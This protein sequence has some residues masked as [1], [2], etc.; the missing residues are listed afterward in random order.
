ME[1]LKEKILIYLEKKK[2]KIKITKLVKLFSTNE[3]EKN[4][5]LNLIRE[6][7]IEGK[8]YINNSDECCK[9]PSNDNL[10][11][12]KLR[13]DSKGNYFVCS[14]TRVITINEKLLNNALLNDIVVV[15]TD[16]LN[17]LKNCGKVKK[18]IKRHNSLLVVDYNIVDNKPCFK[19]VNNFLDC[20][21]NL[22]DKYCK[23][24]VPGDRLVLKV[25]DHKNNNKLDFEFVESLGHKD[26]PNLE[27][28]TLLVSKDI[29]IDFNEKVIKELDDIP[30]CVNEDEIK[31]RLDLR[32]KNIF[33]IDG[34]STKD[35]DDAVSIEK[36]ENGNYILG[37]HIADVAHYVK[38]NTAIFNEALNRGT[39]IYITN[40]VIPMLPRKLSNGICSLNPN[41]DR[42]TMSCIMEVDP[43]GNVVNHKIIDSV[44][45]S[46]MR[47]TYEDVNKVLKEKQDLEEYKPFKQDLLLMNE[48]SNILRE[49]M[50]KRGYLNFGN[51][52]LKIVVNENGKAIGIKEQEHDI[53]EKLIENFMILANETVSKD[54]SWK[55]LPCIYR[56]HDLPP[57]PAITR[58]LE[59]IKNFGYNVKIP[60][61][62]SSQSIQNILNK[63]SKF[64]DNNILSTI[65]LTGMSRACYNTNNIGHFG[66]ALDYYSHFT[67]PIRRFPDLMLHTLIKEYNKL[68]ENEDYNETINKI[69]NELPLICNDNSLK[70]RRADEIERIVNRYKIA[71]LMESHIGEDFDAIITYVSPKGITIRTTNY[72]TGHIGIGE[73]MSNG[74]KF[75]P[76]KNIMIN[77]SS[78]KV[79]KFGDN[80]CV[81]VKNVNKINY[82]VDFSL[83]KS[84]VKTLKRS[85]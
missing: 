8:I 45:N 30:N 73:L 7:E 67:S 24:F 62:F 39:S 49:K 32:D 12:S 28:K 25:I 77:K 79:Y 31:D 84:K 47:M 75:S 36:K 20:N 61:N 11:Q 56:I 42:L 66:L 82:S 16:S 72:V 65:L 69:F 59:T 9:F 1:E 58:A 60:N 80:I 5:I 68:Y 27:I 81:K 55:G 14:N 17:N 34:N 40:Y 23:N 74:F 29:P 13:K 44:I 35:F 15:E 53:A 4:L 50:N 33:T 18:I 41:V 78:G 54:I 2:K 10:I 51:N 46:K 57:I 22:S 70:E 43:E 76:E 48:L 26:D 37:V 19:P 52:D 63:I 83:A 71:E 64:E 38:P 3:E 6:L 21:I 85:K